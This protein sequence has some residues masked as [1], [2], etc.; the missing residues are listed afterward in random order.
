MASIRLF[1]ALAPASPRYIRHTTKSGHPYEDWLA[2]AP[3]SALGLVAPA[4]TSQLRD[5][6]PPPSLASLFP[7]GRLRGKP[8]SRSISSSGQAT[9]PHPR[10]TR[11][12]PVRS[13]PRQR[14][15]A[16]WQRAR[17]PS[18]NGSKKRSPWRTRVSK[19]GTWP[20]PRRACR[21]CSEGWGT[22]RGGRKCEGREGTGATD[23][24]SEP[25]YSRRFLREVFSRGGS[26]GTKV[27]TRCDPAMALQSGLLSCGF[28][29][30][31]MLSTGMISSFQ[32]RCVAKIGP[33]QR[34]NGKSSWRLTS[35][36]Y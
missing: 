29:L 23:S 3:A 27:F 16:G 22:S 28:C 1:H 10:S 36:E 18:R 14:C 5:N 8:P 11:R 2:N 34:F 7:V 9:T 6:Y 31:L 24:R 21:T 17:A 20:R 25:A 26:C 33:T 19:T 12:K 32:E 4:S 30:P 35:G 13:F 15:R